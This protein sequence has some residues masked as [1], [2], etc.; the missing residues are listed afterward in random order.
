MFE[1]FEHLISEAFFLAKRHCS[2]QVPISSNLFL[3]PAK[4]PSLVSTCK[5]VLGRSQCHAFIAL[6]NHQF[7]FRDLTIRFQLIFQRYRESLDNV[8]KQLTILNKQLT[9]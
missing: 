9:M 5:N 6:H 3:R 7:F 4:K 2:A 8:S 1:I